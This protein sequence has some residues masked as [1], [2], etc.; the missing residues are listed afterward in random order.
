MIKDKENLVTSNPVI[1]PNDPNIAAIG[2][3]SL[4]SKNSTL[5]NPVRNATTLYVQ[6]KDIFGRNL[7]NT[8]I[9]YALVGDIKISSLSP[10]FSITNMTGIANS[11]TI[12]N[13]YQS[14]D[15]ALIGATTGRIPVFNIQIP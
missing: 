15:S 6:V 1:I 5:N 11:T 12:W 10:P 9:S 4:V 7:A 14:G 8:G 13:R 2:S 3:L